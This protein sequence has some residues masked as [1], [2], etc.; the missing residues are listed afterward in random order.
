MTSKPEPWYIHA[1]LYLIIAV[2]VVVLIKV[3]IIDPK[4][5]VR[6]EKYNR[7]ESRLRMTNIKEAEI[8]WFKKFGTYTDDLNKLVDF[9]KN[10]PFVDSV[11]KAFDSLTRRPADPFVALSH[12]EFS[13]E[14]LYRT[15]R[16]QQ[17]YILQIDTST[18]IDTVINQYGR[19]LR[20]DTTV[21]IG[22]R[23]YLEDPDGYGTIGSL[24]SDALKNS[25]SW[26]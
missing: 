18:Q 3:A 16:S 11:R 25:A 6:A 7:T 26:E 1:I 5:V 19:V 23:Y 4:E 15:P 9:I 13:P 24:E 2:L 17:F 22:S 10:D 21:V 20:V 14:S 8:L 12:G